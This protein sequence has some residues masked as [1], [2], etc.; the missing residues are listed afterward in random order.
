IDAAAR[1]ASF[2]DFIPGF[3]DFLPPFV[4]HIRVVR[5]PGQADR[6]AFKLLGVALSVHVLT[7]RHQLLP[8]IEAHDVA[9][10]HAYVDDLLDAPRL[11]G[12]AGVGRLTLR[13]HADLLRPHD[14]TDAVAD[15]DIG[16]ADEAGDELGRG[17]LVDLHG[18]ADLLDPTARHHRHAV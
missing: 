13:Q 10:R 3:I 1:L 7:H 14:E 17:L 4:E 6:L 16:D 8:A 11:D 2:M 18:S 12:H 15:E 9:R 5:R